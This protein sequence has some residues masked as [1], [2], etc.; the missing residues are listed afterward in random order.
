[1]IIRRLFPALVA[2][3]FAPA[4]VSIAQVSDETDVQ[5]EIEQFGIGNAYR[6][7][8]V[9]AIRLILTSAMA[10]PTACWVQWEVPN[11]EGDVA[12]Y[13]RSIT[14]SPGSRT[15]VWLYAPLSPHT[16]RDSIWTVRVFEERDGERRRE[17]G[18]DPRIG[19][20][21][22][23][24]TRVE[25]D[26]GMIAVVG[27][28]RMRLE[29][30]SNTWKRRLNPPGAHEA[31][32]IVSGI[33]PQDMPDRWQGLKAFEAVV[34]SDALPQQ[35]RVDSASALREYVRRGGHLVIILPEAG[36]PWG[37][38][39]LGQ[40]W[41]DDLLVGQAPRKDDGVRI[42][43]L[44]PILSKTTA[45][46]VRDFEVSIRVFKDIGRTHD[47]IDNRYEPIVA[48]DDGRV[49]AIQRIVE[50][51]RITIIGVDLTSQRI[52]SMRLPQGDVF[53][54]RILGRRADTPQPD[55][56]QA[57]ESSDPRRLSSGSANEVSIGDKRL[58]ADHIDKAGRAERSVLA[59]V[60]LFIVYFVVAGPGGFYFLKQRR[61][62]RHSW[63]VFAATAGLFTAV[64][65]GGVRI[66][67]QQDIEFR[68]VT[69]LDHVMRP[70]ESGLGSE[71]HFQR[72]VCWGSLYMPSYG[73]V[74]VSIDSDD[75]QRGQDL[76]LTW[77]APPPDTPDR[78]PNVD[79]YVID[80][81][82]SPADYS[83]PVRATATQLYA[84]WV[85]A[86]DPD[87]GG[88]LRV[89]PDDPIRISGG[90]GPSARLSGTIINDLPL[91]LTD[92][93]VFWVSNRRNP[94]RAY[95]Y[96]GIE[97]AW[98]PVSRS[99][100]MLNIGHMWARDASEPW[101]PGTS[102]SLTEFVPSGD[103]HLRRNIGGKYIE[104][105]E[106]DG[107]DF[108]DMG[109]SSRPRG[110]LHDYMEMLSIYHQLGPPKYLRQDNKDP[111]TAV[112]T[113]RL[114]REL[115]LSAWFTRPT[116]IIIGY[117]ENS[118][119]PV[120][121]RVDGQAP[122]STGLTVLR[123]VYPLPLVEEEV[124]ASSLDSPSSRNRRR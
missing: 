93:S 60:L 102:M 70:G 124:V 1:M 67:R 25:L 103:T 5:V 74:R 41:L 14:L 59:A 122:R 57:M 86:L 107:F 48:L 113:R 11:G 114:G 108:R 101:Y 119:T 92:V 62:A 94:R 3:L 7:G 82:R 50:F 20:A 118:P 31:T 36:N 2:A 89:D 28:A 105:E 38:G 109:A 123:W 79:R 116:L 71:P 6:P 72:A 96:D 58:L 15:P 19:P 30:Y 23:G 52:T 51:G 21:R 68:H 77:E 18:G 64:A 100:E 40:T 33:A 69:F 121:L 49:I 56:L 111:D 110:T 61:M 46:P 90:P 37:L 24:A 12:E 8:E 75:A 81:A 10:E 80:I 44:M 43:E 13:G 76:L 115:D 4:D 120:P 88:M 117:L 29:D 45:G 39:T 85:G 35:L 9:T 83:I 66:L 34:W 78:F 98:V 84:N 63:L 73:N 54:N 87:W 95:A 32:R 99:G 91:P 47:T 26:T 16:E 112:I 104:P 27:R 97:Q 53:W 106:G 55:E 17:L 42:S 65:W 22:T